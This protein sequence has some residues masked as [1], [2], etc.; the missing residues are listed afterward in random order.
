M[1]YSDLPFELRLIISESNYDTFLLM[2]LS[3]PDIRRYGQSRK[4]YYLN[5]FSESQVIN[6]D[7]SGSIKVIVRLLP[8]G[9]RHG[10]SELYENNFLRISTCYYNG[11]KSGIKTT[12]Y[13]DGRQLQ[14]NYVNGKLFGETKLLSSE[15]NLINRTVYGDK[16]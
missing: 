5:F 1:N 11:I 13:L 10:M 8:N 15:G 7:D 4:D 14:E 12:Y 3:D 2:M 6:I 9:I 16:S